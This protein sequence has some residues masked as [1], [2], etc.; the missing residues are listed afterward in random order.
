MDGLDG[1]MLLTLSE[2]RR[3]EYLHLMPF[4]ENH[5]RKDAFWVHVQHSATSQ[6]EKAAGGSLTIPEPLVRKHETSAVRL[7]VTRKPYFPLSG[8]PRSTVSSSQDDSLALERQVFPPTHPVTENPALSLRHKTAATYSVSCS[9]IM[10][11]TS[12]PRK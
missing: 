2:Q 7:L 5:R 11:S 4:K 9:S 6:F 8:E 10:P 1:I 12:V 3:S